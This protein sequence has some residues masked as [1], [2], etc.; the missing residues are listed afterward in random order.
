MRFGQK[1]KRKGEAGEWAKDKGER[2]RESIYFVDTRHR[3]TTLF[4]Y[5]LFNFFFEF[6]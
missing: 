3:A 4:F 5:V 6:L 1:A 2:D